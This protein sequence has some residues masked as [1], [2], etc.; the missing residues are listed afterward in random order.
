MMLNFIWKDEQSKSGQK[1]G[2]QTDYG[3]Q[4]GDSLKNE[5]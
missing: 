1:V 5:E 3:D 2:W 4:Y